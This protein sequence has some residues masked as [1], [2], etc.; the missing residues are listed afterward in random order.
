[1]AEVEE[2]TEE[3]LVAEDGFAGDD[4]GEG[5]FDVVVECYGV[6]SCE[7]SYHINKKKGC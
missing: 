7:I 5:E 4:E 2:E 6:D 1:M 3:E